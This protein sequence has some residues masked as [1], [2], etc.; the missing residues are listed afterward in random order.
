MKMKLSLNKEKIKQKNNLRLKELGVSKN[1]VNN[2][3]REAWQ[4]IEMKHPPPLPLPHVP[5][6][7]AWVQKFWENN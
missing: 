3:H 5:E 7:L 6:F 2:S 4:H 1:N